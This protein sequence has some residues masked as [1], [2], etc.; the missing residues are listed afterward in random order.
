MAPRFVSDVACEC[1]VLTW[2]GR[3]PLF[4]TLIRTLSRPRLITMR[5]SLTTTAPGRALCA[6]AD[7]SCAGNRSLDGTGRNEPYN[8]S[9]RLPDSVQMGVWTVT[10]N[11]LPK[12]INMLSSDSNLSVPIGERSLDLDIVNQC[13]NA[14][15]DV[16]SS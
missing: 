8:A 15:M 1:A 16:S 5:S 9:A 12:K 7:G 14:R 13:L 4:V 11:T 2:I 3:S 10:R 6:Y